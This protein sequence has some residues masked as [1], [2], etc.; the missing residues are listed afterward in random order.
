MRGD[1]V[2]GNTTRMSARPYLL[3]RVAVRMRRMRRML[4]RRRPA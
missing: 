4:E 1:D 2:A 3:V